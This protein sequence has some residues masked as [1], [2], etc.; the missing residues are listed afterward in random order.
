MR[1]IKASVFHVV[2]LSLTILLSSCA[3]SKKEEEPVA[4]TPEQIRI[5]ELVKFGPDPYE[6]KAPVVVPEAKAAFDAAMKSLNSGDES[7][8][9]AQFKVMMEKY[10]TLSGSAYNLA[11]MA[12]KKGNLKVA[13][14]YL[15]TAIGR[16][17]NNLNARSLRAQICREEGNFPDA[18]KEY[19]EIIKLWGG[20]LTAYKNL[21]ILYDLYMGD[22]VKALPYYKKYQSLIAQP[23]KQVNG[24]IIDIERRS[25]VKPAAQPQAAAPLETVPAVEAANS[26]ALEVQE[27]G[28]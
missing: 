27:G 9:E 16:N 24:W 3:G 10:P 5:M 11:V 8:A 23:D 21:G 15:N 26:A 2:L 22:S 20:Y 17:G 4:L 25:G 6:A 7:G 19:L 13:K 14:E 1:H 12:K 18:E 28:E